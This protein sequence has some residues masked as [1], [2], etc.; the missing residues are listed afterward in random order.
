MHPYD[1]IDRAVKTLPKL[2]D[3]FV[4]QLLDEIKTVYRAMTPDQQRVIKVHHPL[5]GLL[6]PMEE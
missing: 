1:Q 6:D 5:L 3:G 2:Q 4:P